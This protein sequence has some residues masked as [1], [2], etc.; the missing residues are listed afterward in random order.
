LNRLNAD[1][2]LVYPVL[3]LR[4]RSP[5][6]TCC[7]PAAS[8]KEGS[9]SVMPKAVLKFAVAGVLAALVLI[10]SS[11]LSEAGDGAEQI[12]FR[13]KSS[14]PRA[15]VPHCPIVCAT[16]TNC[17]PGECYLIGEDLQC[18]PDDCVTRKAC[19]PNC[20]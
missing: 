13:M 16:E 7:A 1:R 5:A 20:G 14:S 18:G 17:Y 19:R 9:M 8:L 6:P 3:S 2:Q 12:R 11:G 4:S 10:L 15:A